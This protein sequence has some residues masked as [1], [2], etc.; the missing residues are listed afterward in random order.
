[1]FDL[2]NC[3]VLQAI[4]LSV[5]TKYTYGNVIITFQTNVFRTSILQN[6]IFV[7][8]PIYIKVLN[9]LQRIE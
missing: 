8:V 3:F 6:I 2:F 9:N 7:F 1:M 5:L 4:G